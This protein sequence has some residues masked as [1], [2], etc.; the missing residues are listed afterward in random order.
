[1]P[2][3]V[4]VDDHP[5]LDLQMLQTEYRVAIGQLETPADVQS[6]LQLEAD[7]PLQRSEIVRTTVRDLLRHGGFKPTGRNKPASEYLVRAAEQNKLTC[8]NPVVDI[9]N[10]V[11]L[12][13]GRPISVVDLDRVQ[14]E[15]RIATASDD[16]EYVFNASGQ[17]IRIGGLLCLFDQQGPCAN[18]VRDSQRT[19]THEST[20]RVLTLIW[21]SQDLPGRAIE[22]RSW[23]ESLHAGIP[24]DHFNPIL[25]G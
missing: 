11:S 21:G 14:G 19:K 22:A 6:L 24:A 5:L 8:I 18:S 4:S 2:V 7:A 10:V 20:T 12:H 23:F 15:M 9:C 16:A 17:V 3:S 25:G 1:M 13:S